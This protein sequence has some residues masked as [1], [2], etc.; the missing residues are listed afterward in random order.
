VLAA[1]DD[2]LG[3]RS[4]RDYVDE[5]VVEALAEALDGAEPAP[6][7]GGDAQAHAALWLDVDGQGAIVATE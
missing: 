5:A 4:T 2:D 7:A 6:A 1:W 3:G